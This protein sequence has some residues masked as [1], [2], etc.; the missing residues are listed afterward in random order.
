[1]LDCPVAFGRVNT[2]FKFSFEIRVSKSRT[3]N[4]IFIKATKFTHE[5]RTASARDP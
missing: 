2:D 5:S 3:S 4:Y 1:M